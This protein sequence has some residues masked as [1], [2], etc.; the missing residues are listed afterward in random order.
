[1]SRNGSQEASTNGTGCSGS[2]DGPAPET[3][4]AAYPRGTPRYEDPEYD[5]AAELKTRLSWAVYA[6]TTVKP[7]GKRSFHVKRYYDPR[8]GAKIKESALPDGWSCSYD[9]AVEAAESLGYDGVAFLLTHEDPYHVTVVKGG[10]W[11]HERWPRHIGEQMETEALEEVLE[12]QNTLIL[13]SPSGSDVYAVGMTERPRGRL[14]KFGYCSIGMESYDGGWD[15]N[16][17]R[18][19]PKFVPFSELTLVGFDRPIR[20]VQE[21]VDDYVPER[22]HRKKAQSPIY[23]I[24]SKQARIKPVA[25]LPSNVRPV[26]SGMKAGTWAYEQWWDQEEGDFVSGRPARSPKTGE[27]IRWGEENF[28]RTERLW[29]S[30]AEAYRAFDGN[31]DLQGV[32]LLI[33]PYREFEID[34]EKRFQIFFDFDGCRDPETG[35]VDPRV[36]EEVVRLDTYTEI[37]PSGTGLRCVAWGRRHPDSRTFFDVDGRDAEVYGGGIGG[38]HLITVTGVPLFD[39][40]VRDVQGWID[41]S[42]PLHGREVVDR[43]F[44]PLD[45]DDEDLMRKVLSSKDG[46]L[47]ERFL[48]GDEG[49]WEGEGARYR[50]RSRADQGFFRKLA[51]WTNG[52]EERMKRIALSSKMRRKKW[53]KGQYLDA[54]IKQAVLYCEGEFYSADDRKREFVQDCARAWAS[55]EEPK[56]RLSFGALL[57]MAVDHGTYT[58]EGFVVKAHG[59][60]HEM[61]DSGVWFYSAHR[62]LGIWMGRDNAP[63][64][65]KARE[66]ALKRGLV[67]KISEGK[68]GK[69]TLYLIPKKNIRDLLVQAYGEEED[70]QT[71]M[72][73]PCVPFYVGKYES[74]FYRDLYL[75]MVW[76]RGPKGGRPGLNPTQ[77]LLVEFVL[78]GGRSNLDELSSFT[79]TRKNNLKCRVVKPIIEMRLLEM[80][81]DE[82]NIPPGFEGALDKIFHESGGE[83]ALKAARKRFETERSEYRARGYVVNKERFERRIGAYLKGDL[84]YNDLSTIEKNAAGFRR[85]AALRGVPGT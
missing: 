28:A 84:A 18:F 81:G 76:I 3:A 12:E 26:I 66:P 71:P 75:K 4:P 47:I 57:Q 22:K 2:P 20:D 37:S 6:T 44:E 58:K 25:D 85:L 30:Y 13:L 23:T 51:F 69:G 70:A 33:E 50:C 72:T 10:K 42:V 79:G 21:W 31:A 15:D 7:E 14:K 34:G 52:D 67:L 48:V 55:L 56:E 39:R 46:E 16:Q 5:H 64:V 59:E 63:D 43:E 41:R 11:I 36:M 35:E 49:L 1:M 19:T 40:P 32:V 65:N 73:P 29:G 27:R 68:G 24:D 9:E 83:E 74:P 62:D 54:T 53:E 60:E 61:P 77:K 45:L 78:F 8:T 82:L 80:E 38:R 17:K